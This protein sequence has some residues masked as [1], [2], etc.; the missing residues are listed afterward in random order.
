[1]WLLEQK[2]EAFVA[3]FWQEAWGDTDV[4]FECRAFILKAHLKKTGSK[5][6]DSMLEDYPFDGENQKNY[7]FDRFITHC[8]LLVEYPDIPETRR[9][10]E[11]VVERCSINTI[12][13]FLKYQRIPVTDNLIQ[14]AQRNEI[15]DKE[16]LKLSLEERRNQAH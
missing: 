6:T 13:G 14:A 10:I 15:A 1:M 9:V 4:C 8:C 7:E 2:S 5:M 11:I 12:V 16:E 3:K